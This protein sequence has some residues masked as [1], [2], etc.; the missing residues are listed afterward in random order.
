MVTH[1]LDEEAVFHLARQID[2][3]D[4]RAAYLSQVC[5]GNTVLLARVESLLA[6][7][8]EDQTYLAA[9]AVQATQPV[10]PHPQPGDQIGPFKVRERLAEGGMGVV[11]VAQQTSPVRRKVAVKVIKPGM[12]SSS[13]IARFESERQALAMMDHPNIAKV[14]DAGTTSTGRP[15]FAMELVHGVSITQF[16]DEQGLTTRQRLELFLQVCFAVQHAHQKGI[17]HRDLKPTNILVTMHDDKPMPKV[18]DFGVA[19]ALSHK[20]ADNTVYTAYGQMVGTPVYMSPEQTQ[21]SGLDVDTRSDVYS[22]G[23]LLYELL[24]GTTP[25]DKDVLKNVEFDEMRR[26]IR[27]DEPPRPSARLSTLDAKARSTSISKQQVDARKLSDLFRGELDWIVMKSLEKDRVRRYATA[28]D[29]AADIIRY[30]EDEAV[31][32]CPPTAA[33]RFRKFARRNRSVLVTVSLVTTALLIGFAATAWQAVAAS[34]ASKLAQ[35]HAITAAAQSKAAERARD[36]EANMRRRAEGITASS[37]ADAAQI[38]CEHGDIGRGMLWLAH[39]LYV[40]PP[41]AAE[42][43]GFLRRNLACWFHELHALQ[44]L[45]QTRNVGTQLGFTQGDSQIVFTCNGHIQKH[46]ATTGQ[47]IG[48]PLPLGKDWTRLRFSPDGSRFV[49]GTKAGALQLW[50]SDTGDAIGEQ[51]PLRGAVTVITFSLDGARFAAGS[52]GGT[53]VVCDTVTGSAVQEPFQ[54]KELRGLRALAIT[55]SGTRAVVTVDRG[56]HQLWDTDTG[57]PV[58]PVVE[59][60]STYTV[61]INHDG[62][63]FATAGAETV[64]RMWN[65][66]Q[67]APVWRMTHGGSVHCLAFSPDGRCLVSGG[68]ERGLRVWDAATGHAIGVP[69][70]HGGTVTEVAFSSNGRRVLT[71]SE[72]RTVRIWKLARGWSIGEDVQHEDGVL[73]AGFCVDGLRILTGAGEGSV[74]L[75]NAS[76]G[77]PIGKPFQCGP[78]GGFHELAFSPDGSRAVIHRNGF[79][80]VWEVATGRPVGKLGNRRLLHD[81][82]F[83]P[84]GSKI[85]TG[86]QTRLGYGGKG[87][88]QL[89]E[90]ETGVAC[91]P[92]LDHD[93]TVSC[94]T[95]SP[96]GLRLVTGSFDA[97][98]RLWDVSSG[99]PMG[100]PWDFQSEIKSLAYSPDGTRLMTGF[101]DWTA[102]VW[103][104]EER[105]PASLPLHH[106][107]MV[108][109]ATFGPRGVYLL[110][111]STDGTAR[112]WD[113]ATQKPVGPSLRHQ[114]RSPRASFNAD[115][116]QL[117]VSDNHGT[118]KRWHF[119]L[120]TV[121]R[122]RELVLLWTQVVT[123]LQLESN[124]GIS[125]LDA[126]KWQELNARLQSLDGSPPSEL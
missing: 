23:V 73:A 28:K 105:T 107:N 33:Y 80:S 99:E 63:H 22:L 1:Q 16:A 95:F 21:L 51:L 53:V 43:E 112:V 59:A 100:K 88:G 79:T 57:K 102:R 35:G 17:I 125:V 91:S 69:M 66:V 122:G 56:K 90:T 60:R 27:E 44:T 110:T 2:A 126:S 42:L 104:I 117:L 76:D 58:G 3:P 11:Y 10:A 24:T 31:E 32:A 62:L 37:Y 94:V 13:I 119:P 46:V 84:D 92:R 6:V 65:A 4:L 71:A 98:V 19:K 38:L 85:L 18:I 34:K 118:A 89:W 8:E 124:G 68:A 96:D 12:D 113:A 72:D 29:L 121:E 106:N 55:K 20:L 75:R 123:G 14:L 108:T 50:D 74:Q 30:L 45:V 15:Y 109:G 26:M 120:G 49:T 39:S 54:F 115:G 70:R 97:T 48:A 82:A 87:F 36:L 25:F 77:K 47:A 101:A 93:R 81:V 116:S 9:P 103:N 78:S 5:Q 61:A 83:S 52:E 67:A 86:F 41:E 40:T 111:A 114:C 7:H 64:I